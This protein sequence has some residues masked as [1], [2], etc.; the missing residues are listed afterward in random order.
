MTVAVLF[1]LLALGAWASG[2]Q[3]ASSKPIVAVW[4]PNNSGE[5]WKTLRV[6]FDQLISKATGRPVV[7]KLTTDYVIAIEALATGNAGI[8]YPGA[9]GFIQAQMK[10]PHVQPLVVSSGDS[11]TLDDAAYTSRIVVKTEN[12]PMYLKDGKYTLDGIKGKTFSFV[13]TSSTSG[14]LFP[15]TLIRTTFAKAEGFGDKKVE[16]LFLEGGA[17]KFFGNVV[18]GG[19]HQG[20]L[21]NVLTGK[22]DAGAVDDIDVDSY[23][24][25]VSGTA[26]TS[27]AVY[28]V[29]QGAAAPFD[30]VPAGTKFT[31]LTAIRVQ[32][33]P[34]AVNTDLFTAKELKAMQDAFLSDEATNNPLIFL[35]KGTKGVSFNKQN[36]KNHFIAAP[37]SWWDPIRAM[38]K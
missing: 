19:S 7:D 38:L 21:I 5:D 27:G 32:N 31:V 29:K 30:T 1:S 16:D 35:P 4:Y 2:S 20:S 3:E 8:A 14:F 24:E 15:S 34:I 37:D 11:G 17:S 13:S 33:A 28:Q 10:N 26:N 6:G 12:A 18:F 9:L 25:L 36:G 22:A 23:V